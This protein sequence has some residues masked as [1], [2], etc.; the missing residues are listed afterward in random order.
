M[1]HKYVGLQFQGSVTFEDVAIAFSQ[2]EWESLDSSRGLYRD[3]MLENYRN[4]VSMGH[5]L[6]KPHVIALLERWKEP[7]VTE[8]KDGRRWCTG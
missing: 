8:R 6:S 2:Q 1:A 5:S 3:V 4:L 7:K